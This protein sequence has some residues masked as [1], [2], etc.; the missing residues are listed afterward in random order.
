MINALKLQARNLNKIFGGNHKNSANTANS[1]ETEWL[2]DK[3]DENFNRN[4]S[5]IVDSGAT[6]HM[7]NDVKRF[8]YLEKEESGKKIELVNGDNIEIEGRGM[9]IIYVRRTDGKTGKISLTD[10]LFVPKLKRNLIS[11]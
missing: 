6:S 11:I 7:C 1:E 4:S 9:V 8:V 3:G 10:T 5:W 2:I